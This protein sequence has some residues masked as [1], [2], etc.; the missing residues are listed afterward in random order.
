LNKLPL[1]VT[2]RFTSSFFSP[3][4][5]S[6]A[7]HHE[8]TRTAFKV[9][10]TDRDIISAISTTS[11]IFVSHVLGLL[12]HVALMQVCSLVGGQMQPLGC[13]IYDMWL[14]Y[15]FFWQPYIVQ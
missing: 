14:L 10:T 8:A 6:H 2:Q 4:Y 3:H 12:G 7:A 1:R 9:S 15:N 5:A 11:G 13:G